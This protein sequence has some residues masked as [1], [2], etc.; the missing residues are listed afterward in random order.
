MQR[1]STCL[2]FGM[3]VAL[4][5]CGDAASVKSASQ[6]APSRD[7]G[8]ISRADL[9]EKWPLTVESGILACKVLDVKGYT[10]PRLTA[11][12]FTSGGVT[13]AV[14]G[15]AL[16]HR[17]GPDIDA[18]WAPGDPIWINDPQTKKKVNLGPPKKILVCSS[19][20]V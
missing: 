3:C 8:A 6:T 13:Y 5:A 20:L 19:T 10:G 9:A 15:V 2:A 16:S 1:K 11:V 17:V 7:P 12:T 18:I 14:N 4:S